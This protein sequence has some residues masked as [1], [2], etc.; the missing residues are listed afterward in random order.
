M[1]LRMEKR[2]EVAIEGV[3]NAKGIVNMETLFTKLELLSTIYRIWRIIPFAHRPRSVNRPAMIANVPST[4]LANGIET[5][6]TLVNPQR[7][8]Q[9]PKINI[10]NVLADLI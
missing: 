7:S 3:E 9:I 5:V 2:E 4:I 1:L 10:A 6:S 8:S